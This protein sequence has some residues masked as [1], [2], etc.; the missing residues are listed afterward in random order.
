MQSHSQTRN[1]VINTSL[2]R[3]DYETCQPISHFN[4][5]RRKRLKPF[6]SLLLNFATSLKR[7]VNEMDLA[8]TQA[9]DTLIIPLAFLKPNR[10]EKN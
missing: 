4:G 5:L 6:T 10:P 3:G 7:G 2:Q 8:Y 1:V 9:S